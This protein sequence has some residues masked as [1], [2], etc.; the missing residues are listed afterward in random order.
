MLPG[1][2]VELC[3]GR[4]WTVPKARQAF[5]H[6]SGISTAVNLPERADLDEKGN[7]VL[8]GVDGQHAE[9]WSVACAT[10]DSIIGAEVAEGEARVQLDMAWR[11]DG[12]VTALAAN[13]RIG[14]LEAAMLG[15]LNDVKMNEILRALVDWPTVLDL[16][17]KKEAASHSPA[18]TSNSSSGAPE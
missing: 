15:I 3:D 4:L 2:A 1:H 14:R 17:K 8:R 5:E 6:E 13:Y 18:T 9:L 11:L 16:H 12:A 10:W 7:W